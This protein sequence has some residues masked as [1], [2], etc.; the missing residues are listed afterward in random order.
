MNE[1]CR[2]KGKVVTKG[3]VSRSKETQY[4]REKN[5]IPEE[6]EGRRMFSMYKSAYSVKIP[7]DDTLEKLMNGL[8]YTR[9]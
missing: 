9:R 5:I 6:E 2:W 8:S 3:K 4:T 7:W 1:Q